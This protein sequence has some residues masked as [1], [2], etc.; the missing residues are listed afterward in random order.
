MCDKL[1]N[2]YKKECE[3]HQKYV[4]V[5]IY[6]IISIHRNKFSILQTRGEG[7]GRNRREV[8]EGA[9][10][11]HTKCSKYY[12]FLL[13]R[14]RNKPWLVLYDRM[15]IIIMYRCSGRDSETYIIR[16]HFFFIVFQYHKLKH[17]TTTITQKKRHI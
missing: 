4:C 3:Q 10:G 17:T 15:N 5:I 11:G 14:A 12:Y 8:V 7:G 1:Q 2:I 16:I 13:L 6:F 9:K